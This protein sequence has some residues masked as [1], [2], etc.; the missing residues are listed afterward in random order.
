MTSKLNLTDLCGAFC[1]SAS[2]NYDAAP[3]AGVRF[4]PGVPA[5]P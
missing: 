1:A 3:T 5:G 4:D 2:G